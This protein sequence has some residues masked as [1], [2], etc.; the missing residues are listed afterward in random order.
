MN[1]RSVIFTPSGSSRFRISMIALSMVLVFFGVGW[2][3]DDAVHHDADAPPI[4]KSVRKPRTS[5]S[6][7]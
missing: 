2:G 5:V 1:L 7:G 3:Q 4:L 6:R